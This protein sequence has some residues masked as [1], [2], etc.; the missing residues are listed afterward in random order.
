MEK[1][2]QIKKEIPTNT[3]KEDMFSSDTIRIREISGEEAIIESDEVICVPY[4]TEYNQIVIKQEQ[5]NVYSFVEGQDLHISPLKVSVD[6][7]YDLRMNLLKMLEMEVG[8]VIRDKYPIDFENPLFAATNSTKRYYI[9]ILPLAE[10]D[11]HEVMVRN[12]LDNKY[13]KII[14]LDAKF[15]NSLNVSDIVT[16]LVLT[17]VK[18]YLNI[19]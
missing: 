14:K 15:I 17:R 6:E 5:N 18:K 4:F 8:I 11:Y 7:K 10:S 16:E 2:S 1:F 19:I 9:C 3:K 13:N 12:D